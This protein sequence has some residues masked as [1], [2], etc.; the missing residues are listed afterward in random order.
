[1]KRALAALHLPPLPTIVLSTGNRLSFVPLFLAA[2]DSGAGVVLLDGDAARPEVIAVAE[3]LGAAAIVLREDM[4]G[5][6][7]TTAVLPGGLSALVMPHAE[8]TWR[9]PAE[10]D[11]LILRAT[12]GSTSQPK[13]V[14]TTERQLLNDGRHIIEAMGIGPTDVGLASVPVSH[15]YGMGVLLL[16]LVL[17]GTAL[18]MRDR[19][20]PAQLGEDVKACGLSVMPG[21]PFMYDYFRRMG[22]DAAPLGAIRLLITAGAPIDPQTVRYFKESFGFKVHSLYGTSETG[23]VTF[24]ATGEISD[25]LTVGTPLPETTVSFVDSPGAGPGEGRVLVRGSAVAGR[26]A[27]AEPHADQNVSFT[28]GGFLTADLGRCDARGALVLLGRVSR[29]VNVAGRKVHPRE[30]ERVIAEL[31]GVRQVSVIGMPDA[32]RGEMLVA[33]VR[34]A[35]PAL[36]AAAVRAHCTAHLSPYKVPRQIVFTEDLP[37]DARGKTDRRAVEALVQAAIEEGRHPSS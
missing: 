19:F 32:A 14:V 24:D 15:A 27:L 36:S 17:Q 25:P 23:S 4:A 26:Y 22:E 35:D 1:M 11:G 16:P 9:L 29:F 10:R 8:S 20:L 31:P 5:D 33:C 12:S 34:R 18:A 7:E 6:A 28:S 13:F 30:V 3:R 21:V 2:L 37:V